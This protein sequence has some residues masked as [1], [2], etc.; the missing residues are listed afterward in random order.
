[1]RQ[2]EADRPALEI[3]VTPEMVEAGIAALV[4]VI[5]PASARSELELEA[6]AVAAV[7]D[8]MLRKRSC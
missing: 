5:G 7:F 3:E 2:D 8:A 4:G 1:M 6:E